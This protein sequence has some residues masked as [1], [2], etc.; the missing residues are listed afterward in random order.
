MTYKEAQNY[1]NEAPVSGEELELFRMK[2]LLK[3]LGDP[4]DTLK[5]VHIAGTN[6]KGSILAYT[7]NI[8]KTAGYKTGCYISPTVLAY[9][10]RIQ[11][12]GEWIGEQSFAVLTSRVKVAAEAMEKR[13]IALPSV[14]ELETVI[15]FL[16]FCQMNCDIVVLETGLGGDKDA[17]NVVKNTV[18]AAFAS[19]SRDHMKFLGNSLTEIAEKKAG[20]IKKGCKVISVR[21]KSHEVQE[22]L[23]R[24]AEAA[25]TNLVTADIDNVEILEE[26]WK[27][28]D[29]LVK[30]EIDE[31]SGQNLIVRIPMA[32][33]HQTENA[34]AALKIV[35][36]LQK[37]GYD[38][39]DDAVCLGFSTVRWPGRFQCVRQ[40]PTLIVDGAHNVDAVLRLRE[41]LQ[42]FFKEKKLRFIMGVFKDK[43]YDL[44]LETIAPMA[45]KIY[46]INLPL[47]ERTLEADILREH[48]LRYCEDVTSCGTINKA[49]ESALM[50]SDKEDVIIAF[51]SLSCIG[52]IMSKAKEIP[53]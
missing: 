24:H 51:G 18:V 8:L 15:A 38:I 42:R 13:G 44:I 46:T 40:S 1:L 25:G 45:A 22:V 50:D 17:T 48:A 53:G 52:E 39:S 14:F 47:A 20:I 41:T 37:Y 6:G 12:D 5:F 43:E 32:G 26:T 36:E 2:E 33:R 16:Y 11:V 49:V 34:A 35:Y 30:R 10:E 21:Q 23:K 3:E 28:Q 31:K 9:L 7:A 4:Q 29:L 19:I 27:Y